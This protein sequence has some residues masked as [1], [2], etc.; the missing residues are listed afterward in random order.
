MSLMWTLAWKGKGHTRRKGTND[1]TEQK[2]R[3]FAHGSNCRLKQEVN[4][5]LRQLRASHLCHHFLF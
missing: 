3:V 4:W 1:A 2:G 5:W